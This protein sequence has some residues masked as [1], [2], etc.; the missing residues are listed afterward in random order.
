MILKKKAKIKINK[1]TENNVKA[2]C[3]TITDE[4]YKI[5]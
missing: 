3:G 4:R 1:T 2:A 5:L